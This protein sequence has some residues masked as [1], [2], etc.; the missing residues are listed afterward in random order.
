MGHKIFLY[1]ESGLGKTS[2][3][4]NLPPEQTGIVNIDR[5]ALPLQGWRQKYVT[6]PGDDGKPNLISSNYVE[7]KTAQ[8]VLKTLEAWDGRSDILYII[9]DTITHLIT[10]EYMRNALGKDFS[11]YQTMGKNAFNILDYVRDMTSN[12][13]VIGHSEVTYNDLGQRVVKMRSQGRMIDNMVPPSFFTTVLVPEVQRSE[14]GPS[15][16][17]RTQSDG[18]DAAKSPAIFTGD[19]VSTALPLYV[20]NDIKL[21]FDAL[22]EFENPR[23]EVVAEDTEQL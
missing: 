21:V 20:P 18:S 23:G 4:R 5:K 22:E 16:V 8:G 14:E 6:M 11:G 15:Y 12:V 1:G 3:I 2:S 9:I 19:Q 13:L 17:F 10:H 7:P